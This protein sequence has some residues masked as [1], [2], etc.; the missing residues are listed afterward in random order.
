MIKHH[1]EN[2]LDRRG[3]IWFTLPYYFSLSKKDKTET[4]SRNLASGPN[5]EVMEACGLLVFH[6][7][8]AGPTVRYTIILRYIYW[9]CC[10]HRFYYQ[11]KK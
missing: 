4:Q 10:L 11:N 2:K 6:M 8:W 5:A 7:T 1:E 3:F 9:P